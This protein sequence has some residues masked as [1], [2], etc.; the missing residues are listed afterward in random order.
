MIGRRAAVGLSLLGALLLCALAAQGASA[1]P[2]KNTTAFTC[3]PKQVAGAGFGEAHCDSTVSDNAGF[4][5]VPIP[6]GQKTFEVELSNEKVK[7]TTKESEPMVLKATV[8]GAAVEVVCTTVKSKLANS[9]L[10]NSEPELKEHKITGEVVIEKSGCTVVKP[11]N[12]IVAEPV[13]GTAKVEGV[14]GLVGPN[15]EANAMGIQFKGVGAEE[16]LTTIE[17]KDKP[18]NVCKIAGVFPVKGS[19]IATSGPVPK[20]VQT[21]KQS[22]ATLVFESNI[23]GA[24]PM[25]SLKVA[26]SPAQTTGILTPSMFQGNPIAFTTPT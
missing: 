9:F 16:V 3:V 21:N 19:V 8:A 22:G 25:Q 14:E 10:L 5:H 24:T 13:V 18:P 1:A 6:M 4:I 12:C 2:G 20:S 23:A 11:A 17:F 26:G 7:N 15:L